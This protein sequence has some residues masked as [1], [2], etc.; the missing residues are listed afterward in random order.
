MPGSPILPAEGRHRRSQ[1]GYVRAISARSIIRKRDTSTKLDVYSELFVNFS[2]N[3]I[4][5]SALPK[6]TKVDTIR[7]HNLI[8][9][10]AG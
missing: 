1:R 4:P 10:V 8:W 3:G 7:R 6:R 5:D 9:D 2:Y